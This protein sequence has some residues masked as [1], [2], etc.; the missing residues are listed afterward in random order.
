MLERKIMIILTDGSSSLPDMKEAH[1][2]A[3]AAG[4]EPLGITLGNYGG[5]METVFGKNRNRIIDDT[6]NKKL[7]SAAFIDILKEKFQYIIQR[8]HIHFLMKDT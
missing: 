4:I 2:R 8:D 7:I 6:K 1:K 3:V 5:N